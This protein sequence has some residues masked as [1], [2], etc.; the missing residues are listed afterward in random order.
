MH[1]IRSECG[2]AFNLIA[3]KNSPST[4]VYV[5]RNELR[6]LVREVEDAVR[7]SRLDS[8]M[9]SIDNECTQRGVSMVFYASVY[10]WYFGRRRAL[11]R[12]E[13][14]NNSFIR[15]RAREHGCN[16]EIF[17]SCKTIKTLLSLKLNDASLVTYEDLRRRSDDIQTEMLVKLESKRAHRI[18]ENSKAAALAIDAYYNRLRSLKKHTDTIFPN[19]ATFKTLPSIQSITNLTPDAKMDY[20][21]RF[22]SDSLLRTMIINDLKQWEDKARHDLASLLGVDCTSAT[23]A[24][25]PVEQLDAEHAH[26]HDDMDVVQ[27]P[28]EEATSILVHPIERGLAK[29]LFGGNGPAGKKARDVKDLACRHCAQAR[30]SVPGTGIM[31][32][33]ARK[34]PATN[35]HPISPPRR[36]AK[37]DASKRN[38]VV[39][40]FNGMRCHLLTKHGVRD[41]RDEDYF[42]ISAGLEAG[43]EA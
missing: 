17:Q 26:R 36:S 1:L 22:Q 30:P 41:I 43:L 28:H 16:Y 37:S 13:S 32:T 2:F 4:R 40:S 15:F 23:Q 12:V 6:E 33:E 10:T 25:H 35:D 9:K 18:E 11:G 5:D 38:P 24:I 34:V 8:L 20:Q 27:L 39:F 7:E 3:A 29:K 19:F 42:R 31:E 14:T 21:S